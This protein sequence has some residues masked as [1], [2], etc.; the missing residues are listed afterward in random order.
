MVDIILNEQFLDVA[1]AGEFWCF[2][3]Q[4]YIMV[5]I[6]CNKHHCKASLT[7]IKHYRVVL[8]SYYSCL[9]GHLTAALSTVSQGCKVSCV[10]VPLH[11]LQWWDVQSGTPQ[12]AVWVNPTWLINIAIL[13]NMLG[14]NGKDV[15]YL[16]YSH[17][18]RLINPTWL[19]TCVGEPNNGKLLVL[20]VDIQQPISIKGF[21]TSLNTWQTGWPSQAKH[22]PTGECHYPS[23]PQPVS[24][25][26]SL[27]LG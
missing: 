4:M 1:T 24:Q 27:R 8:S 18:K 15:G 5:G 22:V 12:S 3:E 7:S 16:R 21:N 6:I 20:S 26:N 23:G 9:V 17:A 11:I 14:I 25:P 10:G 13:D 19:I 2:S